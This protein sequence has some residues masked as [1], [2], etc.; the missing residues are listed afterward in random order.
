[1]DSEQIIDKYVDALR[2]A[3]TIKKISVGTVG[4][5]ETDTQILVSIANT[6]YGDVE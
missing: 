2:L 1:M 6:I 4:T 3:T 5:P